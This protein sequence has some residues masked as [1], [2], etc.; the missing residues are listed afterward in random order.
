MP[1]LVDAAGGDPWI[2]DDTL[3]AGAPGEIS[4]LAQAFHNSG[5]CITAASD[6][7]DAAQKRFTAAWD[8]DDPAH[9]IN[10]SLEVRRATEMMLLNFAAID[11]TKSGLSQLSTARD[12]YTD[13]LADARVDMAAEGYDSGTINGAVSD[14]T[15]SGQDQARVEADHYGATQ[16]VEDQALVNSA[17]AWT[18]EKQSAAGR[19]RDFETITTPGSNPEA[20]RYAGERLGDFRMATFIG[21]LAVDPVTGQDARTRAQQRQH[22]QQM[23]ESGFLTLPPLNP[24]QV[25]AM[26]D[27]GEA[28]ARQRIMAQATLSLVKAGLSPEGAKAVVGDAARGISWNKILESTGQVSGGAGNSMSGLARTVSDGSHASPTEL[29]AKDSGALKAI[30]KRLNGVGNLIEAADATYDIIQGGA[31]AGRRIGEAVGGQAAGAAGAVGAAMLAGSFLGP[32][33][34]IVAATVAGLAASEGG[35]RLGGWVG[36]HFDS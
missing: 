22:M 20:V 15:L 4:Q 33:G 31:P 10:D 34:V 29:S 21:P 18:P 11:A 5:V 12:T 24:D 27:Q 9:P 6:E 19:L 17:G 25:T 35:K 2:I 30:G 32:G 14:G 36:S 26:L 7:F 28:E 3:Q 16:R 23:L 13:A 8:R 1:Q